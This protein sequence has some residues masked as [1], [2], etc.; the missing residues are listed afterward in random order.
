MIMAGQKDIGGQVWSIVLAGGE[1]ERIKPLVQR[2]LGRH[3]PKQYCSFVGTR[4]MFQP[5]LDRAPAS[6]PSQGQSWWQESFAL[7]VSLTSIPVF[8]ACVPPP[9][10]RHCG[11]IG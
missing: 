3:R 2:W 8:A 1:G 11:G 7:T 6:P 4:S 5:T 10:D 9:I